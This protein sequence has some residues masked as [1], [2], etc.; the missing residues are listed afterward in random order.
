MFAVAVVRCDNTLNDW[1]I[2]NHRGKSLASALCAAMLG[3]IAFSSVAA[4]QIARKT[5]PPMQAG[6]GFEFAHPIGDFGA[7][8]NNGFGGTGYFLLGLDSAAKFGIRVDVG[9]YNFGSESDRVATSSQVEATSNDIVTGAIGPELTIPIG[10]VRPYINA[11]VGIAFFYTQKGFKADG[12]SG[13]AAVPIDYASYID[14]SPI[15]TGG[16][17]LN[18]PVDISGRNFA[19]DIG[20]RFNTITAVSYY[21][22]NHIHIVTSSYD[23]YVLPHQAAVDFIAYRLGLSA[24][25]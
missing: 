25:F 22:K 6:V 16:A 20:A 13:Q 4:A 18:I 7:N 12:P 14:K 15:Y 23:S 5:T 21:S 17:G 9:Y 11:G 19:I 8:E 1:E 3:V 10:R 2:M 24:R